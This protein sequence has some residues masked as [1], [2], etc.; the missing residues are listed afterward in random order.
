MQSKLLIIQQAF[1][2]GD[3]IWG[4]TIANDF[5]REGYKILWP[6]VDGLEEGLNR[7]YPKVV[8]IPQSMMPQQ[9]TNGTNLLGNIKTKVGFDYENKEFTEENGILRL[10]MR[11]S[12]WLMGKQYRFHME[13]KYS[14]LGKDWH[15]WKE[16]AMPVRDK[17]REKKLMQVLALTKGER[18]RLLQTRYGT[19]G[20]YNINLALDS[21]MRNVMLDYIPGYSLFDWCGVIENATVIHAVSSSSLYLFELLDLQAEHIHLYPRRPHEQTLD[22][23]SFFLTKKYIIHE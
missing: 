7:A 11:Y 2:L 6:V 16:Y 5:T 21:E 3:I 18:Y 20:K 1:G 22:Y 14:Y 8:F 17:Q 12:E 13:S 15:R 9:M 10:P 19:E 23:V 4:Q